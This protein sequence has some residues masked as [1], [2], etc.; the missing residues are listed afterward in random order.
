[1]STQEIASMLEDA[2]AWALLGLTAPSARL[3]DDARREVAEH[4]LRRIGGS[5]SV[6]DAD[7][8]A[9]PLR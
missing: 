8:L 7:Q 1:M 4:L 3:R 9:L 6:A 2:P 5:A